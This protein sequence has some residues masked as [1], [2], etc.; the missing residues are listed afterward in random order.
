MHGEVSQLLPYQT[1]PITRSLWY[2]R[3][4]IPVYLESVWQFLSLVVQVILVHILC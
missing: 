3:E 2:W 1:L 4:S